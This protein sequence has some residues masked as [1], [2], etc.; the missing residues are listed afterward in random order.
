MTIFRNAFRWIKHKNTVIIIS[1]IVLI[2]SLRGCY[3]QQQVIKENNA[4][5][6]QKLDVANDNAATMVKTIND[7]NEEITTQKQL[8]VTEKQAK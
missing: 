2:F 5:W 1:V 3:N 6:Q 4:A 8:V 7:K